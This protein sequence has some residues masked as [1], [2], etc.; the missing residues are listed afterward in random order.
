MVIQSLVLLVPL[1]ETKGEKTKPA[2]RA[3][4]R[5]REED[6]EQPQQSIDRLVD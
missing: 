6:D 5:Q 1:L 2:E 4:V 3:R